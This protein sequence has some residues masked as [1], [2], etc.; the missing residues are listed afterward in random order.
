MYAHIVE[1]ILPSMGLLRIREMKAVLLPL[2]DQFWCIHILVVLKL[3]DIN[4]KSRR[5]F[6]E[7]A[8]LV[9]F[10]DLTRQRIKRD[11][12]QFLMRSISKT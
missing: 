8:S 4:K 2:F 9:V 6:K 7:M 10:L 1:N 5:S 3:S 12:G 11:L